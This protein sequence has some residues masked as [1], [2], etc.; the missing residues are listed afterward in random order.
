MSE[1]RE[2]HIIWNP[3]SVMYEVR[4]AGAKRRSF[5]HTELKEAFW[6]AWS[7]IK[8]TRIVWLRDDGSVIEDWRESPDEA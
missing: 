4:R 5:A 3:K 7:R 2:Y 1:E 8:T 6:W